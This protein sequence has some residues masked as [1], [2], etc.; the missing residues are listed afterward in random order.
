MTSDI[1]LK[2]ET[3]GIESLS[4]STTQQ[5]L[6]NSLEHV[7]SLLGLDVPIPPKRLSALT[8]MFDVV[9]GQEKTKHLRFT[10]PR[11]GGI[12]ERDYC[13]TSTILMFLLAHLMNGVHISIYVACANGHQA[14]IMCEKLTKS[15][16]NHSTITKRMLK[17]SMDTI[18]YATSE[19]DLESWTKKYLLFE[20]GAPMSKIKFGPSSSGSK[21]IAADVVI[22]DDT[23]PDALIEVANSVFIFDSKF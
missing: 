13:K 21:G 14:K 4:I 5:Q 17:V 11:R 22:Y 2:T 16:E 9:H 1:E 20:S 23:E 18:I 10:W 19:Y 12:F 6:Q 7:S 15:F 8:Q 3:K